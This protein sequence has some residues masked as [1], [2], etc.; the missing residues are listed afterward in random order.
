MPD[1]QQVEAAVG[2]D[3]AAAVLAQL[4]AKFRRFGKRDDSAQHASK[5]TRFRRLDKSVTTTG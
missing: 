3:H 5:L 1:V 4:F 2:R